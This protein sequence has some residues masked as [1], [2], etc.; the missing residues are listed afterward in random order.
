MSEIYPTKKETRHYNFPIKISF[1]Y[2]NV[3]CHEIVI[4]DQILLKLV[5]DVDEYLYFPCLGTTC[6]KA[7]GKRVLEAFIQPYCLHGLLSMFYICKV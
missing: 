4:S 1:K 3:N 5:C 6:T 7:N 2:E